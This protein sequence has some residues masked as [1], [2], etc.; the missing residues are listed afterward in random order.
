MIHSHQLYVYNLDIQK[1]YLLENMNQCSKN[2]HN[3][4][5][6]VDLLSM[7]IQLIGKRNNN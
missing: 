7:V 4:A 2:Y 5:M 3:A 6:E 1:P